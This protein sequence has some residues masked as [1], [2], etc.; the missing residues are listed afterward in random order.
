MNQKPNKLLYS[1]RVNLIAMALLLASMI[2]PVISSAQQPA[3]VYCIS[4]YKAVPGKENELYNM[5]K[6]VDAK[7]QQTRIKSAAILGWYFY[8]LLS[9]SG[10]STDYD[11]M[12]VT[13]VNR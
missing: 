5:I 1:D 2:W 10:S 8:K 3:T 11:Y 9:P 7:V 13:I 4:Y 12:T 6:S